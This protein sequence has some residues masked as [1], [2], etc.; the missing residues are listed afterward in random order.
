MA[1]QQQRQVRIE[2]RGGMAAMQDLERRS[3]DELLRE[4]RNRAAALS[5]LGSRAAERYDATAARKYFQ[6]AVAAAR[7]QE[8]PQIRRM[9]E[10]SLAMAERRT[11]D[12]RKAAERLGQQAPTRRQ[13]LLLQFTNVVF[14]PRGS[15]A[16]R[17]T[18]GILLLLLILV[19]LIGIGTL[20]STLVFL[21]FGGLDGIA[22][23]ISIGV[24]LTIGF[25]VWLVMFGRRRQRRAQEARAK[26]TAEARQPVNRSA[27]R[28][29]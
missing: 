11:G 14:P 29:G 18:G 6:Q 8:R 5:I 3:D 12:L 15:G 19:G 17:R 21:P 16:L 7:P 23:D 13:L 10:A 9:A 24:L 2:Q 27:R 25:L 20:I 1:K 26:Q 22:S 28:R 4:T